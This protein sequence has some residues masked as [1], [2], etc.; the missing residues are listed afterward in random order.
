[1]AKK[2]LCIEVGTRFT[3]VCEVTGYKAN[4]VVHQCFTFQ[5]PQGAFEDG[6]IRDKGSLG[7]VIKK[8]LAE[9]KIKTV[10]TIFTINSTKV[11]NR[12]VYIPYVKE[13][14]IK[15]MVESQASEYFPIDISEY[16]IAYYILN[17]GEK[18]KGKEDTRQMKLLLL[19]APNNLLQSYYN[20]AAAAGLQV[21]SI[22]YI[23]NGF[24]QVAKRQLNQGVNIS[25]HIT[26]NISLINI[27]E[28]ENLLLQRTI[29]YGVNEIIE[30]VRRNTAFNANS[31]EEAI[32]LLQKEKLINYQFEPQKEDD[33]KYMITS[34]GYDQV[35]KETKAKEDVTDSLKFLVNNVI[36]VLDYFTAKNSHKKIGLVYISGVGAKFQGLTQLF[37][38]ELGFD[39]KKIDNI[40]VANFSKK[41]TIPK[42]DLVDYIACIGS[43]VSPVDFGVKQ[44][45]AIGVKKTDIKS[46]K[47]MFSLVCVGCVVF[48]GTLGV[49]DFTATRAKN[50][51]EKEIDSLQSAEE[52]YQKHQDAL[53]KYN[54][55]N[56]VYSLTESRVDNLDVILKDLE[57]KM[58]ST[59][60]ITKLSVT[61]EGISFDVQTDSTVAISKMLM[62]LEEIPYLS[63][64]FIDSVQ[65]SEKNSSA[66][67]K[68]SEFTVK[69]SF[70]N[71]EIGE[72]IE[73]TDV[74]SEEDAAGESQT[75]EQ[76][77]E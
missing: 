40:Y 67:I 14:K 39:T 27:L 56:S 6:Y 30:R 5:T 8:T 38:N 50:K 53:T 60:T 45:N 10:D 21:D 7:N 15:S 4:P 42:N 54:S 26:E 66:G 46:W 29:P 33:I 62:N 65:N 51:L 76:V 19:A 23:G 18:P 41:I 48:I 70:N 2:V 20:L 69:S 11:A 75:E 12:E 63:D 55:V 52:I 74:E 44:K 43:A 17:K 1:M 58:P 28:N 71:Y 64:F 47:N 22:D 68:A 35:V 31:D 16:N 32:E 59:M 9:H 73:E 77:T 57:Q 36:R 49:I 37:K 3:R 13:N 61:Q 24:Y 34:E 25:I 72:E